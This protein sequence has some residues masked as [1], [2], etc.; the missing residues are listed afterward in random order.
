MCNKRYFE[1][2]GGIGLENVA[3]KREAFLPVDP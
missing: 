2:G 1:A 3:M